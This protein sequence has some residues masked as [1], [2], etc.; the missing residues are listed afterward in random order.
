MNHPDH[1]VPTGRLAVA[2]LAVLVLL[3]AAGVAVAGTGSRSTGIRHRG[4]T[5]TTPVRRDLVCPSSDADTSS[6]IGLLPGTP[7]GGS[8]SAAGRPLGLA[9]GAVERVGPPGRRAL[10]VTARGDATRGIFGSRARQVGGMTRCGSPR[11]SW[12]FV[13]AGASPGHFSTLELVNP[14]SGPAVVD[15]TVWGRDGEVAGAGLRGI[16]VRSGG[17]KTLKLADVAPAQGNLAVHV[18]ASRG[19]VVA[20]VN[21]HLVD[22]RDPSAAPVEEWIPDQGNP[23]RHQLLSGLPPPSAQQ[24]VSAGSALPTG[25]RNGATLVIANPGD[26]A[27]VAQVRLSGKDGG[28]VPKGLAPTQ[29]PPQSVVSVPLGDLVV[30]PGTSVRVDADGPVAAGYVVPGSGD[31][32]HAVSAVPWHG[33]A[34]VALAR[35]G[36]GTLLLTALTGNGSATITQLGPKGTRIARTQVA[37]PGQS[38]VSTALRANTA[39]VVVTTGGT[40]SVAGAVL[41]HRGSAYSALPLAPVQAV[42]QV[43]EVRPAG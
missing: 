2:L 18:Q 40:G 22:V 14:R 3:T 9:A 21:D 33:P 6:F 1:P 26:K 35:N 11:A 30:D 13:G 38:T 43:P 15:L 36:T 41:V 20:D 25:L 27:V 42:L 24:P 37:V 23:S 7:K 32:L 4:Q 39:S 31:L 29:V 19:L 10:T 5:T 8:V 34:A 17:V 12:W 16:S 28:F